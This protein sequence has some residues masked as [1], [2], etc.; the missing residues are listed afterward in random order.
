[1]HVIAHRR[2][3]CAAA[4][5]HDQRLV[6]AAEQMPEALV[7]TI[8]PAGV[9]A[10]KPFHAGDQV[11]FG[12][13]EPTRLSTRLSN[14]YD[15]TPGQSTIR[16]KFVTRSCRRLKWNG[17]VD[18]RLRASTTRAIGLTRPPCLQEEPPAFCANLFR[19]SR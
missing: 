7:P 18:K 13:L 19:Q 8:E 12:R 2:Q 15:G 3:I 16:K 6:T 1:M 14:H 5:V 4:A 11:A 17:C 9:S 10:Q